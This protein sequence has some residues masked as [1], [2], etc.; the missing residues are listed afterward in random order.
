MCKVGLFVL[1]VN[2]VA[3]SAVFNVVKDQIQNGDVD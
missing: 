2:I 1:A 3:D